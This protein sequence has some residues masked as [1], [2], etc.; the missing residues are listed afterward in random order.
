MPGITREQ[1]L[2]FSKAWDSGGIKILLDGAAIQFAT[3]WANI[4]LKSFIDQQMKAAMALK[5]IAEERA[6]V[7]KDSTDPDAMKSPI[8]AN[9]ETVAPVKSRIILTD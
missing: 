9:A 2:A 3:D 6:G 8:S 4:V 1:T 5:K 7:V